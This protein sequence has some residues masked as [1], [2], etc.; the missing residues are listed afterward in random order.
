MLVTQLLS[1]SF[2]DIDS[3]ELLTA[4]ALQ[5]HILNFENSEIANK[6]FLFTNLVSI[7]PRMHNCRIEI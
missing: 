1:S 7:A 6:L 4:R 2:G 5:V 3:N